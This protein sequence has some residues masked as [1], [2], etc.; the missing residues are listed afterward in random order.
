ML[1]YKLFPVA[2]VHLP[3]T[4]LPICSFL[5]CLVTF[6]LCQYTGSMRRVCS[7]FRKPRESA[8]L[9]Y[10]LPRTDLEMYEFPVCEM[11]SLRERK[12]LPG[13]VETVGEQLSNA[14]DSEFFLFLNE[15]LYF[16]MGSCY[17]YRTVILKSLTFGPQL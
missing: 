8:F 15:L 14:A 7:S 17:P 3:I 13:Y 16:S 12:C 6:V 1:F 10:V 11:G 5:L 4:V 2:A 9:E